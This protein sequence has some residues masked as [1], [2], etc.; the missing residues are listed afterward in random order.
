M[1]IP[2][3]LRELM[4]GLQDFDIMIEKDQIYD[5]KF[6]TSFVSV[7]GA[8]TNLTTLGLRFNARI[9]PRY[10]RLEPGESALMELL[11]TS[12]LLLPSLR[13]LAL[14]HLICS[15]DDLNGFLFRHAD[16]LATSK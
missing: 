1:S 16:I 3:K 7:L 13:K 5:P 2:S 14:S 11:N 8:A 9:D 4:E 6:R 15:E 12:D 10:S